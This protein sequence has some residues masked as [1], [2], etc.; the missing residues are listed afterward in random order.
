MF[1]TENSPIEDIFIAAMHFHR[2]VSEMP[3]SLHSICHCLLASNYKFLLASKRQARC[4]LC[5]FEWVWSQRQ[6]VEREG[7]M[8]SLPLS[9]CPQSSD[10]SRLCCDS[11][12]VSLSLHSCSFSFDVMK[13]AAPAFLPARCNCLIHDERVQVRVH[14][15]A[16]HNSHPAGQPDDG[17]SE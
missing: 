6:I 14:P 8:P 15:L 4:T 5:T 17:E 2:M 1:P 7:V 16:H 12:A 11:A 13:R 3:D 10:D 9:P